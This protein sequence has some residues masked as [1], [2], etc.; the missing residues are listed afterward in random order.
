MKWRLIDQNTCPLCEVQEE[1]GNKL[2]RWQNYQTDALSW[3]NELK[4]MMAHVNGRNATTEV[5]RVIVAGC[6]CFLWQERNTSLPRQE[7]IPA[8]ITRL[9]IRRG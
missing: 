9:I 5:F 6:V 1:S 8:S 2:L 4:W 3:D 7:E